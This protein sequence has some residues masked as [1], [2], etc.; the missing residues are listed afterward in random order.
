MGFYFIFLTKSNPVNSTFSKYASE[1]FGLRAATSEVTY[2]PTNVEFY[3]IFGKFLPSLR[4][5]IS[6]SLYQ[7]GDVYGRLGAI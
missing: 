5:L 4:T 1:I 7:K 2:I 6:V 3:L